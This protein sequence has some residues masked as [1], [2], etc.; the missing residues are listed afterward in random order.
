MI[1][2]L[3]YT[4]FL[5]TVLVEVDAQTAY[6]NPAKYIPID[7]SINRCFN[8]LRASEEAARKAE[9]RSYAKYPNFIDDPYH[10]R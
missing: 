6:D 5:Q 10:I 8:K 7:L 9:I 2:A 1:L 4:N 3:D